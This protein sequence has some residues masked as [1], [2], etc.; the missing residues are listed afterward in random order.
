MLK[1]HF[2]NVGE[3][4]ATL[5]E[6]TRRDGSV[7]RMLVDCGREALFVC[8][9]SP[10]IH[11]VDYLR[12]H[13]ITH[14]NI[15]VITHL[16]LDHAAGLSEI[17]KTCT[18]D[19]VFTTY[20]PDAKPGDPV[21]QCVEE[22]Q[23]VNSIRK[24]DQNLNRLCRDV[25]LLQEKGANLHLVTE[26]SRLI[27]LEEMTVDALYPWK[28]SISRQT[29]VFDAMMAHAPMEREEKLWVSHALNQNSLRLAVTYAGRRIALDADYYYMQ[30]EQEDIKP[31]DILKVGHHG[32]RKSMSPRLAHMLRPKYA[33]ISCKAD[34]VPEKDRPSKAV[35]DMLRAEGA[36]VYYTDC[37]YEEGHIPFYGDAVI[38]TIGGDGTITAP[39][40]P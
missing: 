30:A 25:C 27:T 9:D 32:D 33:V 20:L 5:L 36:R 22:P 35:A 16:H 1:L 37:F 17:A 34:Y 8:G 7:Y 15:I 12:K 28:E 38:M 23:E 14:I 10:C 29:A 13:G 18:A 40:E 31:C 3:G 26:D 2:I 24:L 6:L 19:D 39:E 4:D 21:P 11:A